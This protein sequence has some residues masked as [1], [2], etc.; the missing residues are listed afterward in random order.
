[1]RIRQDDL[2]EQNYDILDIFA[3]M[4]KSRCSWVHSWLLATV[5]CDILF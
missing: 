5:Y 3:E 1:M 2:S 4:W